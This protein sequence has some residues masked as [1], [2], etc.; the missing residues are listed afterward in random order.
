VVFELECIDRVYCNLY[1]PKLQ[2]ELG[3]ASFIR[4]HLGK[5]VA[6]TAVLAGRT[7]AFYAEVRRFAAQQGVPVVEFA[8]GCGPR[9]TSTTYADFR[10]R[11]SRPRTKASPGSINKPKH[12]ALQPRAVD[13]PARG[14]AGETPDR[15]VAIAVR[16]LL[17]LGGADGASDAL[18]GVGQP[19]A[20]VGAGFQDRDAVPGAAGDLGRWDPGVQ[21]QR[22][23]RL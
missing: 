23:R 2:R 9:P 21:L 12:P 14:R 13:L 7:E 17:R 15:S 18:V 6:S 16:V 11:I 10:P 8:S 3:V 22:H 5:P 4:E 1:V 20:A 19:A